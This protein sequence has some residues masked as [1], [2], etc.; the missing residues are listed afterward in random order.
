[1]CR[2]AQHRFDR[3]FQ[4][5]L[6]RVKHLYPVADPRDHAQIVADIDH[7]HVAVGGQIAQ[8]FE[9]MRLRGDIEAGGRLVQQQRVRL[10]GQRHGDRHALLLAARQLMRIAAQHRTR[11]GQPHLRQKITGPLVV[12]G[13]GQVAMQVQRLADLPP[14]A[15]RRRQRLPRILRDEAKL[16]TPDAH[17]ILRRAREHVGPVIDHLARHL[18]QPVLEIA[19]GGQGQRALARS[20]FADDADAFA[21]THRQVDLV[22]HRQQRAGATKEPDAQPGD[23]EKGGGVC[24]VRSPLCDC[25]RGQASWPVHRPSG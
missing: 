7:R 18:L 10:A 23:V 24:H 8:Q 3:A 22:Q 2:V 14:D 11:I 19:H 15:H 12:L 4:H 6:A 13:L 20:A 16:S 9:D 5:R 21:A 1:M 17:E 25:G